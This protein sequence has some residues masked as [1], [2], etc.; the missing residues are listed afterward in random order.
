MESYEIREIVIV[1]LCDAVEEGQGRWYL[2]TVHG[3]LPEDSS[4]TCSADNR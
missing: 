1:D 4:A 3:C 2:V